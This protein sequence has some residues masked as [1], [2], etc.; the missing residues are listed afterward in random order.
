[1]RGTAETGAGTPVIGIRA[2]RIFDGIGFRGAGTILVDGEHIAGIASDDDAATIVLPGDAILAPGFIDLQVNGGGGV[3]FND[4]LDAEGLATI[5]AAHARVGTTSI[6]PTLISGSR[7]AIG[8]AMDAVRDAAEVPGIA[9]L[10]I[11]GPFIAPLRRG[12]HPAAAMLLLTGED[13]SL[14]TRPLGKP[15]MLTLAPDIVAAGD[16]A[17]LARAGVIVFAGHSDADF[18]TVRAAIAAGVSGFT[19]LFNA[20]SPLA[21]REPGMIGAALTNPAAY[22]GVIVDLHHVHPASVALAHAA[23]GPDRLFLVSDAMATAAS[24]I[25]S[26]VL[27]GIKIRLREGRLTDAA[28]TLAGAHLTMAEAV[29]NA[30]AAA[31]ISLDDAL[32]MATATPA[33]AGRLPDRGRIAPGMRADFV[34]L[35][36]ELRVSRVWQGGTEL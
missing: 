1:M 32:R 23:F 36:S 4:A 9:G 15:L 34:V 22:A 2:A 7:A 25:E 12:I 31:G 29:R 21:S 3:M 33:A 5:A 20:M 24:D 28:G 11:E 26:F 14:V 19:H 8:A 13:V 35:D 27:Y 30:V 10:H 17:A 6:F 18:A 16:I